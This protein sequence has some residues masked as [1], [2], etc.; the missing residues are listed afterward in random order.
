[1]KSVT[2]AVLVASSCLVGC[3]A[4]KAAPPVLTVTGISASEGRIM[5]KQYCDDLAK[6][7]DEKAMTRMAVRASEAD[8]SRADQD[9]IVEYVYVT[10]CPEQF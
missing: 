10:L 2:V 9:A 8:L 3:G 1:M 5:A 4:P 6:M 7:S